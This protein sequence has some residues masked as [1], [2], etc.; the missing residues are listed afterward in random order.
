MDRYAF[1]ISGILQ[2]RQLDRMITSIFLHVNYIHLFFN[3]F[4]FYSFAIYIEKGLG[5]LFLLLLYFGSALG[6]NL[7]ALFLHKKHPDYRA[8]GAS[9]AV[10]GVIFAS[11]LLF[12]G[13]R[14]LVFPIPI[15]LPPWLFAI[16]F[17]LFSIYGIGKQSGNIGHEAHLGGALTGVLITW[18]FYPVVI[19]NH[20]LLTV[21]ITLPVV[22]F[23]YFYMKNP[24]ILALNFEKNFRRRK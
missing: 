24:E 3:L 8:I 1:W 7:L 6:G 12:P 2:K 5:K 13:G 14:I 23:L 9:G 22:L 18:L 15:G 4:S 21:I 19:K 20:L 16:L 11:V 10:S 17:V